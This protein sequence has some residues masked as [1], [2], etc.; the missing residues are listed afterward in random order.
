MEPVVA[1]VDEFCQHLPEY[2]AFDDMLIRTRQFVP[3]GVLFTL[4]GQHVLSYITKSL[5]FRS[6]DP[7]SH[8]N[9]VTRALF[10][11]LFG[12]RLAFSF[13][14]HLT[15]ERGL[16]LPRLEQLAKNGYTMDRLVREFRADPGS[17]V[18]VEIDACIGLDTS[19]DPPRRFEIKLFTCP[20]QSGRLL[21]QYLYPGVLADFFIA[22][23]F[24]G[25][26]TFATIHDAASPLQPPWYPD[27]LPR[28]LRT[29]WFSH[30]AVVDARVLRA[31]R[32]AR[33]RA[34]QIISEMR[35]D[36]AFF[37]E[38]LDLYTQNCSTSMIENYV[39]VIHMAYVIEQLRRDLDE[40]NRLREEERRMREEAERQKRL[41]LKA[42]KDAGI[43]SPLDDPD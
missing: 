16:F 27:N 41:L 29:G 10:Q 6:T 42:L 39:K 13:N 25:F 17:F 21:E 40:S 12:D 33:E 14:Q 36:H 22:R 28:E 38:K 9:D 30:F 5:D 4:Y 23:D 32:T 24:L 8:A 43:P 37:V 1:L 20:G 26:I 15:L 2:R 7:Y 3:H 34:S 31:T 35:N 11:R 18:S 19:G